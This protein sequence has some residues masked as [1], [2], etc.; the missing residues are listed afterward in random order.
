[1]NTLDMII[2]LLRFEDTASPFEHD[3]S[4]TSN[5]NGGMKRRKFLGTF[6]PF[7]N[8][9]YY[10]TVFLRYEKRQESYCIANIVFKGVSSQ[11][12]SNQTQSD[13]LVLN[14]ALE[15]NSKSHN[16]RVVSQFP[17]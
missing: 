16:A 14:T 6:Q 4:F 3:H 5:C 7:I 13:H 1:M 8:M 12:F 10:F 2:S 15:T 11:Q 17:S 9:L